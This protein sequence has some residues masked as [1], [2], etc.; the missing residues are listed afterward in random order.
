MGGKF[1]RR[2][3]AG[4][5]VAAIAAWRCSSAALA[6]AAG[7]WLA[8]AS[9]AAA[10]DYQESLELFERGALQESV[11]R[12]DM[13]LAA[14]PSNA[15]AGFLKAR[16]LMAM[17]KENEALATL[18]TLAEERPDMPELQNNLAALYAKTGD[19]DRAKVTLEALTQAQPGYAVGR[20][21]LASVYAALAARE[22]GE[23]AAL[24]PEGDPA[25]HAA[26]GHIK[27]IEKTIP[28]VQ[29]EPAAAPLPAA[30]PGDEEILEVLRRWREA[31]AARDAAAF[32]SLYADDY[33][34]KP[35]LAPGQWR[36]SIA[37]EFKAREWIAVT[38][39]DE[40]IVERGENEA[41]ARF[42][43]K[44]SSSSFPKG[45]VLSKRLTLRRLAGGW[46][47]TG[48]RRE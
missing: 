9:G 46:K 20:A 36:A 35:G 38:L 2:G 15:R 39:D 6:L 10:D 34:G 11:T 29:D 31:W 4:A 12:L 13:M 48:E 28:L 44:Y 18:A 32:L 37:A 33:S 21:N 30:A 42:I 16:A 47:I 3:A 43:Q 5:F 26:R 1:W 8:P 14:D 41:V 7:I 40:R 45:S 22:W 19:L 25:G 17:G 24:L 23:Y 27:I